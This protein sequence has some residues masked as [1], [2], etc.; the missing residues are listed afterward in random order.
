MTDPVLNAQREE[1]KQMLI[2]CKEVGKACKLQE[3]C[4]DISDSE[5]KATVPPRIV[6]DRLVQLYLETFEP[7]YRMFHVPSF[8]KDYQSFW[9]DFDNTSS[10]FYHILLLV[11]AIGQVFY[12]NSDNAG[13]SQ[14]RDLRACARQWIFSTYRKYSGPPEKRCLDMKVVQVYCLLHLARGIVAVEGDI[15]NIQTGT[16]LGLALQIGLH[17]DPLQTPK[18]RMHTTSALRDELW[19]RLWWTVVEIAV[20]SALELGLP[21]MISFGDFNTE[22]PANIDDDELDEVMKEVPHSRPMDSLTQ[23]SIQLLLQKSLE[24][25]FKI[26]KLANGCGVKSSYE[27]VIELGAELTRI[28]QMTSD[29]IQKYNTS[30]GSPQTSSPSSFHQT[31]ID[32]IFRRS[33]IA[34]HSPF[35]LKSRADPR[36]YYSRK[37]CVDC[38]LSITSFIEDDRFSRLMLWSG[39]PYR[40]LVVHGVSILCL[41]ILHELEEE[42]QLPILHH[43]NALRQ[44]LR[45]AAD[46]LLQV[47]EDRIRKA[48][49][50]FKFGGFLSMSMATIEAL[51][52]GRPAESSIM[53]AAKRNAQFYLEAVKSRL[54][55]P[56]VSLTPLYNENSILEIQAAENLQRA[57]NGQPAIPMS[58]EIGNDFTFAGIPEGI[59]DFDITQ[60]WFFNNLGDF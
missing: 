9:Q 8:M 60:Q 20:D 25:R 11:M 4:I 34:L 26:V 31:Y 50:N 47:A 16:M 51:E 38:A 55:A 6:A 52:N 42:K 14:L 27:K 5:L 18:T 29:L 22:L 2:K 54:G 59:F 17:R 30:E 15:L 13:D 28:C 40:G 3:Q 58:A 36:F 45:A 43:S 32:Y 12:D 46:R 1:V 56:T 44:P 49:N 48:E 37:I 33:L 21:P 7:L 53:E 57:A 24:T 23:S 41:D 19:R 39:G 10:H 35:A